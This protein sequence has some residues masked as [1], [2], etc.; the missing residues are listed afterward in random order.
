M[1]LTWIST[2]IIL[3]ITLIR[4]SKALKYNFNAKTENFKK[5]FFLK[6]SKYIPIAKTR[7]VPFIHICSEISKKKKNKKRKPELKTIFII[8]AY[9][10]RKWFISWKFPAADS[11][12]RKFHCEHRSLAKGIIL[13]LKERCS[14]LSELRLDGPGHLKSI[15][16]YVFISISCEFH[17]LGKYLFRLPKDQDYFLSHYFIDSTCFI[18]M[19]TL[20]FILA[21]HILSALL[22]IPLL[23]ALGKQI[24][25][26]IGD[27]IVKR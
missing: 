22:T 3:T 5:L 27:T 21:A 9:G 15:P 11:D 25:I 14:L 23:Q 8:G 12:Q 26:R 20:H 1:S 19:L 2:L 17:H 10:N 13:L 16:G 4:I 24:F 18:I 6:W 7:N